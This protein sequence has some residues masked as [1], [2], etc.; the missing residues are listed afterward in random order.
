MTALIA[1]FFDALLKHY[2]S[3]GSGR[4]TNYHV[5]ALVIIALMVIANYVAYVIPNYRSTEFLIFCIL[6]IS[7]RSR[8]LVKHSYLDRPRKPAF[9]NILVR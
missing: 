2:K 9:P 5:S 8:N 6:V 7:F 3:I 1:L 4:A